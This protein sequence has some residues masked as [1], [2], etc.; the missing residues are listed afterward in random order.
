MKPQ[1]LVSFRHMQ[2]RGFASI[3][4]S[5]SR[6]ADSAS[7]LEPRDHKRRGNAKADALADR[8]NAR[9]NKLALRSLFAN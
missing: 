1:T 2:A 5:I 4:A 6:A 9:A 3:I 7:P 8:R